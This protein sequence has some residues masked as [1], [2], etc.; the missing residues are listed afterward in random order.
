MTTITTPSPTTLIQAATTGAQTVL[1][2]SN[3][4]ATII[5]TIGSQYATTVKPG[6]PYS[7]P[8]GK[9][10]VHECVANQKTKLLSIIN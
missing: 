9:I 6:L 3:D 7:P 10:Y 5:T 8:D 1:G 2:N 4:E